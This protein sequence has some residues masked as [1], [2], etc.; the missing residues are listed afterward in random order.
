M[1]IFP[2]ILLSLFILAAIA[3]FVLICHAFVLCIGEMHC[4]RPSLPLRVGRLWAALGETLIALSILGFIVPLL[5]ENFGSYPSRFLLNQL[6]ILLDFSPFLNS[7]NGPWYWSLL[8]ISLLCL[9]SMLRRCLRFSSA[10]RFAIIPILLPAFCGLLATCLRQE[11]F[12]TDLM[13]SGWASPTPPAMA[14]FALL[15]T[16]H[17]GF[18]GSAAVLLVW[19]AFQ[20]I[21]TGLFRDT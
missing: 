1:T 19:L 3:A 10:P 5:I 16:A 12:L 17:L 15:A 21:P 14:F 6:R 18:Y 9:V 8:V 2:S 20:I 11:F 4:H 7:Y 13:H